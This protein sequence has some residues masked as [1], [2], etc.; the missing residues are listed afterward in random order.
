MTVD[1][2]GRTVGV[3]TVLAREGS[4]SYGHALWRCI[5]GACGKSVLLGSNR[6]STPSRRSCGCLW[7]KDG[8]SRADSP[9]HSTWISWSAMRARCTQVKVNSYDRY[10]GRGIKVCARWQDFQNFL[11]DMGPRPSQKHSIDR[12]NN[13]GNYTSTNC[14]WATSREQGGNRSVSKLVTLGGVTKTQAEWA[15]VR[16]L[17]R[18]TLQARLDRGWSV[19]KALL[20]PSRP[21]K[22]KP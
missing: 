7:R 11:S 22:V 21:R 6:L 15:R 2:T 13:D 4:D 3:L 5:C 20:T 8:Y 14:R 16:G 19:E 9:L 1:F 17:P 12:K 10:G 18:P